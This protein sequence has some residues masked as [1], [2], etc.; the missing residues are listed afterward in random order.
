MAWP[1]V[2]G[3][4]GGAGGGGGG[5]RESDGPL[6]TFRFLTFPSQ[7]PGASTHPFNRWGYCKFIGVLPRPGG[8]EY[9]T[10]FDVKTQLGIGRSFLSAS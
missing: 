3:G 7:G 1:C 6:G 10:Y 4:G 9:I 8:S 2:C 5:Q